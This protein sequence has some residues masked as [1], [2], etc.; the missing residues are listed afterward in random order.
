MFLMRKNQLD[1]K[2]LALALVMDKD[3]REDYIMVSL[4]HTLAAQ[5]HRSFTVAVYSMLQTLAVIFCV[6]LLM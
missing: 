5:T 3:R 6:L 1:F 2:T 4:L